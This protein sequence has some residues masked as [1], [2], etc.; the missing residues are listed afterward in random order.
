MNATPNFLLIVLDALR[1]DAL[2]DALEVP[3]RCHRA[4]FC[5][6]AAPW[7]LPSCTSIVTGIAASRHGHFWRQPPL[8]P[9]RLL[10]ALPD[11]YR[12]VGVVNNGAISAGSGVENGF[13]KWHLSLDH[14]E[15][16]RRAKRL[17]RRVGRRPHFIVLH[18]NIVHDYCLPVASR[19][20]PPGTPEVL[21]DRVIDWNDTTEVDRIAAQTTYAACAAAQLEQVKE[22]LDLVRGRDDFI[23]AVTSDHG[24][25]FDYGL[26]RIH[27]GG[28]VHQDLLRVP[29]YIDLPTTIGTGP[30]STVT[31]ALAT[32]ALA[33]TDIIPTL[34]DLGGIA[35]PTG[36]D[37]RPA[38]S[39]G[40]RTLVSE[41]RRYLYV[42]D[43]F[44]LN[45]HGHNKHMS[46]AELEK[47]RG[48]TD[49]LAEAPRIRSFLRH[50]RKLVV[51][52]LRW[53]DGD[54]G[55]VGAKMTELGD[56][57]LGSPLV[58]SD[59]P[60]LLAFE[61]FDVAADPLETRNLLADG[62]AWIQDLTT[63]PW[64][65]TVTLPES[66]GSEVGLA[67]ALEGYEPHGR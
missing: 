20:V 19:Y 11:T 30:R 47:N 62:P 16:F 39:V 43:R 21:G 6:T 41:D 33:T 44:R 55:L 45:Y 42:Q 22:V 52:A 40:P 17:I 64:A 38:G 50:P 57:L 5:V 63:G 4:E 23:T 31:E 60:R 26:Q 59:G 51:T 1:E 58:A 29:F 66:D 56:H 49:P 61:E 36:V 53:Q 3:D 14:D 25:G 48:L 46:A 8:G 37:G 15:P 24:E 13:D 67:T 35:T 12:K 27:H 54:A 65:A 32:Q 9:N 2:A 10:A 7:T 28:R 18:S 34:F